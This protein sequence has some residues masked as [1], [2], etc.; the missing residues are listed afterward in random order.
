M[1]DAF[2]FMNKRFTEYLEKYEYQLGNKYQINKGT[3]LQYIHI[4]TGG[5]WKFIIYVDWG[6]DWD[7]YVRPTEEEG[8]Y[9][10]F[11]ALD[12]LLGK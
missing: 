1:S 8:A 2:R 10:I 12:K 5:K 4:N 9:A 11:D 3:Y 7:V 6:E